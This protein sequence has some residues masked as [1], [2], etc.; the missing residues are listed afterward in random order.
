MLSIED[1]S[2]RLT[3]VGYL[4]SREIATTV[5]LAERLEKPM[6]V[7]GPAGVGQDR[8][9]PRA[10]RRP[11]GGACVRLQCYEGLDEAQGALRVGVR[12]SSSSTPRCCATGSARRSPAPARWPRRPTGIAAGGQRLL[13]RALPA[14]APAAAGDPV[15]RR[16]RSCWSTRSTRPIRS[17]RRSSSRCW[18]TA[19]VTV[20]E[21]G[22]MRARHRPAR[23]PHLQRHPRAVRRAPAPLPP[24]LSSTSPRRS[25]SSPSSA[26]ACPRRA[27]GWRAAVVAAVGRLRT[28][29]LKKAPSISET[30]DWARALALLSADGLD[31]D[32]V[33]ATL[34][35][36][37]K[38]EADAVRARARQGEVLAASDMGVS[39]KQSARVVTSAP[40][41]AARRTSWRTARRYRAPGSASRFAGPPPSTRLRPGPPGTRSR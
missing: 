20:P 35:L 21:L 28:L 19:A 11:P 36:V 1:C 3:R 37:L 12:A 6:L 27:R 18:P 24:P 7:E 41:P 33:D 29:D 2:E 8:A 34:N 16:R 39:G 22:T 9:R 25:A 23:G 14:P 10:R 38:A 15:R 31:A 13:Q 4:P 26:P 30:L 5:F 32:L 17:S 40:T